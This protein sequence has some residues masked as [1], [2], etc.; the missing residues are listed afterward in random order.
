MLWKQFLDKFSFFLETV[1]LEKKLIAFYFFKSLVAFCVLGNDYILFF[2]MILLF[3]HDISVSICSGARRSTCDSTCTGGYWFP[4][5]RKFFYK[6]HAFPPEI[7]PYFNAYIFISPQFKRNI[8][9][10]FNLGI[11][12]FLFHNFHWASYLCILRKSKKT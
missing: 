6:K 3:Q 12:Y 2:Y 4:P 10:Q 8:F 11:I 5:R 1:W 9:S 7:N